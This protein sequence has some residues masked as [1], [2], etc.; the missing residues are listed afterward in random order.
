VAFI[1]AQGRCRAASIARAPANVVGL[2]DIGED[3]DAAG[4]K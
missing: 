2:L 3:L 1:D 4:R